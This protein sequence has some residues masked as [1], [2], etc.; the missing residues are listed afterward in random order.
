MGSSSPKEA[1]HQ[2]IANYWNCSESYYL[3]SHKEAERG[4]GREARSKAARLF[5]F[6]FNEGAEA[7][8]IFRKR[9]G[10]IAFRALQPSRQNISAAIAN[11]PPSRNPISLA[12]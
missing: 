12:R 8:L 4:P 6:P 11:A 2:K 9:A 3:I 10:I 5:L 1:A 7:P